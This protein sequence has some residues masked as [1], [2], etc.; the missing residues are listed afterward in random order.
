M[1]M[2]D[3]QE[4]VELLRSTKQWTFNY[5]V[6]IVLVI[7]LMKILR[8]KRLDLVID[9]HYLCYVRAQQFPDSHWINNSVVLVQS[10]CF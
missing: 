9:V 10:L 5:E 6:Q 4:I 1:A 8:S 3:Y 7:P 2:N